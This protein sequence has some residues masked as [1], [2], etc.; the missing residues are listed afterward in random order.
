MLE[1]GGGL[2][3]DMKDGSGRGVGAILQGTPKPPPQAPN[4][5]MEVSKFIG[6]TAHTIF[7]VTPT[8]RANRTEIPRSSVMSIHSACTAF[9]LSAST[10]P[11]MKRSLHSAPARYDLTDLS[12]I[13][14]TNRT[15]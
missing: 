2:D 13:F 6:P 4:A 5:C 14:D 8:C 7:P 15:L 1:R 9:A 11:H 12:V 3:L 10:F